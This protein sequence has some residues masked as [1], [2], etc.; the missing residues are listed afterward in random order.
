MRFN[1]DPK[2]E[3]VRNFAALIS[4]KREE[5]IFS[6]KTL[7]R[8]E[9]GNGSMSFERVLRWALVTI[10]VAGLSAG[11]VAHA[12]GRLGLA[13]LFWTLAT[14]PVV[15]GLAVSIAR[16]LLAGRFGVDAIA[17]ISMSAAQPREAHRRVDDHI[18]EVPISAV[19]IGD[20]LMGRA[21]VGGTRSNRR[22]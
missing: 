22:D 8:H 21:E 4:L 3:S 13:D 17:V 11:I 5:R 1:K 18:E 7:K 20:Q 10:A 15:A 6:E 16:D 19:A 9:H 12:A 14:S 2:L